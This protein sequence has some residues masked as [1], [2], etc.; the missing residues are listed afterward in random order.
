VVEHRFSAW[1]SPTSST[2]WV[3]RCERL[4]GTLVALVRQFIG[5]PFLLTVREFRGISAM[6]DNLVV[7]G[8][9]SNE[10]AIHVASTQPKS[11][12]GLSVLV[13]NLDAIQEQLKKSSIAFEGPNPERPGLVGIKIQDPNGNTVTFLHTQ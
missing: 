13:K 11:V 5:Q 3:Q 6:G 12:V 8:V 10:L 2:S 1:L 9:G 7:F 4:V